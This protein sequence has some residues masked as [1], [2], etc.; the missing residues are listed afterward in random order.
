MTD[1][2]DLRDLRAIP[3]PFAA[4]N[5]PPPA[6]LPPL[7]ASPTRAELRR[8]RIIAAASIVSY[9]V[10]WV[11]VVERRR[12]LPSLPAW[13]VALGL[14]VPLTAAAL[15]FGAAGSKGKRGLGMPAPWLAALCILSPVVF[16][17]ATLA[18]SP[19]D[20]EAGHFWDLAV[21]CMA[22]TVLLTA[23]PLALG[24]LVLRHAFVAASRWRTAALGIACGALAAATM[25]LAC[26]HSGA[27]H[28]VVGHGAMMLVG[29]GVGALLGARITR[30]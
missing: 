18:T 4:A 11:V 14:L 7:V 8:R 10:A 27:L 19:P 16:V 28:V 29:G 5:L 13:T 3:D 20:A 12:D 21:R 2:P 9:E 1:D 30:S 26:W 25:S 6:K 23:V 24:V 15:A 17:L 22:V